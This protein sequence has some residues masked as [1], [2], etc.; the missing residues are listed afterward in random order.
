[1]IQGTL[2]KPDGTSLLVFDIPSNLSEVPL[3][4]YIDFLIH[5]REFDETNATGITTMA[6]AVSEFL[7]IDLQTVLLA[8]AGVYNATE[9][10]YTGAITNLYGYIV[11]LIKEFKPQVKASIAEAFEYRGEKYFVPG[12][13]R[14]AIE[15]EFTLPDLSVVDVIEVAEIA[16]FKQHVTSQR[17]DKD[18]TLRKRIN[19]IANR[20]IKDNH[21]K[22]PGGA[23]AKAADKVY[24]M[25]LERA[26]DPNGS[27]AFTYYLQMLA[28][29]CRKQGE[30]L[31]FEDSVREAWIQNRAFYFQEIDAATALEADFFLTSTLPYSVERPPAVGFLKNLS[32]A[33]VAA[34]QLKKGKRSTGRLRTRKKR[35][36]R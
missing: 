8:S 33:V 14:Q 25:E 20:E 23:I 1:M 32:F 5:C 31:P 34:T 4:R 10:A 13:V 17:G 15:G 21:G 7:G 27:L 18:G 26:G 19:D 29:L 3:S 12:I 35:S 24:N 2:K 28:V 16:R 11:K 9:D 22:D 6:K 36:K 30:Q